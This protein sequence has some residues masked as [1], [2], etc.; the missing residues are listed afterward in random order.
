MLAFH[1]IEAHLAQ[2]GKDAFGDELVSIFSD[3][4]PNNFRVEFLPPKIFMCG[5]PY[6][7][8]S[9]KPASLRDRLVTALSHTEF[10][11]G[12][13]QAEDFIDYFKHG[14]YNDLLEFEADIANLSTMIIICLESPGSLVELGMFC[15]NQEARSKLIVIAPQE[16]IVG[17]DSF[18]FLGPL[19]NLKEDF[20]D[21]VQVYPWPSTEIV[22]YEHIDL[23]VADIKV[24]L[25]NIDKSAS[26]NQGNS[27]HI[28]LLIY[29]I[30]RLSY[31]IKLQEID[32]SLYS[33]DINLKESLITKFIY[34]L[35]KM[36]L[37]KR[38][39]YS[40]V[41]YYYDCSVEEKRVRF[42]R[43]KSKKII[44][45]NIVSMNLRQTYILSEEEVSKK[46]HLALKAIYAAKEKEKEKEEEKERR[47]A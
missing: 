25:A 37:V 44:E 26:F 21:A 22:K 20:P 34:L 47:K 2:Q 10:G 16:Q 9:V 31:P 5:G 42:G 24:K 28:A 15:S 12:L 45:S 11:K 17:E 8:G 4:D 39:S 41:N 33:M 40:S 30:I 1:N 19:Q 43:T 23:I 38:I 35:M 46:R 18:I 14:A 3:L 27:A 36:D 32:L 6:E 7:T 13:V 29:E